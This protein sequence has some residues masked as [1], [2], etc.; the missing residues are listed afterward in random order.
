[1]ILLDARY[2]ENNGDKIFINNVQTLKFC[3]FFVFF[4]AYQHICGKLLTVS[5]LPYV[6]EELRFEA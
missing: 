3:F 4:P 1:M 6:E 5:S 2:K